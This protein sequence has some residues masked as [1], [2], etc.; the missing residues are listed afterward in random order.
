MTNC[1]LCGRNAINDEFCRY[2]LEA[3]N[4]L[5]VAYD[6]WRTATGMSWEEYMEK[7]EQ[8]EETGRWVIDVIDHIRQQSGPSE[9]L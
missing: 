8:I 2:H 1:V 7:L 5:K 3:L 9:E 6:G 4:N